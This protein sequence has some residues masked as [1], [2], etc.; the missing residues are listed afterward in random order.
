MNSIKA[1]PIAFLHILPL[2]LGENV[3]VLE[4]GTISTFSPQIFVLIFKKK[5]NYIF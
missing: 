1:N 5:M 3:A 2:G 4:L